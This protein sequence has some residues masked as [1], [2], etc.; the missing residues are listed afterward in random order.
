[1]GVIGEAEGE[2]DPLDEGPRSVELR[3]RRCGLSSFIT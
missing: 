3:I 1:M 2:E